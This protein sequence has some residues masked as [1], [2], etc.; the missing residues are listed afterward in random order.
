MASHGCDLPQNDYEVPYLLLQATLRRLEGGADVASLAKCLKNSTA[1]S[2]TPLDS[3]EEG[4]YGNTEGVGGDADEGG[5][6]DEACI[7]AEFGFNDKLVLDMGCGTGQ[8]FAL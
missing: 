1:T 8:S 6:Y 5:M 2:G 3:G 7:L 4:G